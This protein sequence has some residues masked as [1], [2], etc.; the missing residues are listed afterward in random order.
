MPRARPVK[1]EVHLMAHIATVKCETKEYMRETKDKRIS[2]LTPS[3]RRG[4]KNREKEVSR[5]L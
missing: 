5:N 1:E 2:S 3:E 4:I